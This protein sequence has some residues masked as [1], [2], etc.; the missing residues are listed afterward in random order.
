MASSKSVSFASGSS[1]GVID[2]EADIEAESEQNSTFSTAQKMLA[3]GKV[4][5]CCYYA[6]R[7]EPFAV[8]GQHCDARICNRGE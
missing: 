8:C 1:E 4:S 7:Y 6:I 2:L 5:S 3:H